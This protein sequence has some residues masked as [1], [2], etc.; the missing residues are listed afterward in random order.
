MMHSYS[1]THANMNRKLLA[2]PI[3]LAIIKNVGRTALPELDP[4]TSAVGFLPAPAA[5][6]LV[7]HGQDVMTVVCNT[8]VL[9]TVPDVTVENTRLEDGDS[10]RASEMRGK[11]AINAKN[12]DKI[13][14]GLS[15]GRKGEKKL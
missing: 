9:T 15:I 14:I 1:Y 8:R 13:L 10:A 4:C 2:T 11:K 7:L 3:P 12:W 5:D 6:R